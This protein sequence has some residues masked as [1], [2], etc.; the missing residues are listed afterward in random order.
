MSQAFADGECQGEIP[1]PWASGLCGEEGDE[2]QEFGIPNNGHL[3]ESCHTSSLMVGGEEGI[4]SSAEPA[5]GG[6]TP[7]EGLTAPGAGGLLLRLQ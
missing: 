5:A 3:K 6:N 1:A 2:W 4:P 7:R